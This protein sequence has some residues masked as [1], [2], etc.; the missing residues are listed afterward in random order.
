MTNP[1]LSAEPLPYGKKASHYPR[2]GTRST[3]AFA[4][5]IRATGIR[6]IDHR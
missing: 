3:R 1:Y 5:T 6:I 2:S 4:S